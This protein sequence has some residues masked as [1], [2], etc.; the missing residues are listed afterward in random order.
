MDV[1]AATCTQRSTYLP[2][3]QFHVS[4]TYWAALVNGVAKYV[5][6]DDQELEEQINAESWHLDPE[7]RLNATEMAEEIGSRIDL[8]AS[9]GSEDAFH[10]QHRLHAFSQ[11]TCTANAVCRHIVRD[12][13][14]VLAPA[15]Q[16]R[17]VEFVKSHFVSNKDIFEDVEALSFSGLFA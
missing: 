3:Y 10:D 16:R 4:R 15:F 1:V 8:E 13:D 11:D 6:S 5:K 14:V 12:Q 7:E 9:E 17:L 2:C